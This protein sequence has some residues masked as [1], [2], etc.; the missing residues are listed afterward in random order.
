MGLKKRFLANW[1]R[2]AETRRRGK[3]YFIGYFACMVCLMAGFIEPRLFVLGFLGM[4]Y[5]LFGMLYSDHHSPKS[6]LVWLFL[7]LFSI[8]F[9]GLFAMMA[10]FGD[11]NNLGLGDVLL[12]SF[13][14]ALGSSQIRLL[15]RVRPTMFHLGPISSDQFDG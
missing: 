15:F 6:V 9:Y 8:L 4:P 13:I 11:R 5:F 3:W 12:L 1:H 2:A 14:V 10:I 7:L